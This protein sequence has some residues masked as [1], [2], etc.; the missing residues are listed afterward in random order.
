MILIKFKIEAPFVY[1]LLFRRM[2][3]GYVNADAN[4]LPFAGDCEVSDYE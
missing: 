4:D 2:H 3:L 1:M